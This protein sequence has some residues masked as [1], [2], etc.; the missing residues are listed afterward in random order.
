MNFNFY[1]SLDES[2]RK[3]IKFQAPVQDSFS[4]SNED[5]I[6]VASPFG[7]ATYSLVNRLG[8]CCS[9][10]HILN[11]EL[12]NWSKYTIKLSKSIIQRVNFDEGLPIF[13][14]SSRQPCISF[15]TDLSFLNSRHKVTVSAK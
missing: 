13:W 6:F 5:Y 11:T 10:L 8:I 14:V 4:N 12:W 1:V 7:T 9:I 2:I 15:H 3:E